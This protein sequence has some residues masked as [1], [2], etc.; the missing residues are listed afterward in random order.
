MFFGRR[1]N[2][3]CVPLIPVDE[4]PS[5]FRLKNV[6]PVLHQDE[7]DGMTCV[8]MLETS[9]CF[10]VAGLF[11][12]R[13]S[14]TPY[15][16]SPPGSNESLVIKVPASG[17]EM[18]IS[19][20][21]SPVSGS[22]QDV[23]KSQAVVQIPETCKDSPNS[24]A[25]KEVL[26]PGDDSPKLPEAAELSVPHDT[27][28]K[29]PAVIEA[30]GTDNESPQSPAVTQVPTPRHKSPKPSAVA[31][32]P[33]S[34]YNSPKPSLSQ[35]MHAPPPAETS[36]ENIAS[37]DRLPVK[38]PTLPSKFPTFRPGEKV[39]CT[40]WVRYGVCDFIQQGCKYRHEMPSCDVLKKITGM[41][42]MPLWWKNKRLQQFEKSVKRNKEIGT[43]KGKDTPVGRSVDKPARHARQQQASKLRTKKSTIGSEKVTV[44]DSEIIRRTTEHKG[45]SLRSQPSHPAMEATKDNK[46][47]LKDNQ[48]DL[49]DSEQLEQR[50]WLIDF[51]VVGPGSLQRSEAAQSDL[52]T[53]S[54]RTTIHAA[55]TDAAYFAP[56]T[57]TPIVSM[58]RVARPQSP[59]LN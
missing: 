53:Q 19:P 37:T 47:D 25:A 48:T 56:P 21:D 42:D 4:L 51:G 1:K 34:R 39:Y 57:T 13:S 22:C 28:P 20:V 45:R 46:T 44:S 17:D 55:G 29:S 43:D 8:G 5:V 12:K 14:S 54:R 2:G 15:P 40:H 49:M 10:E 59:T 9:G 11:D 16:M 33:G 52:P 27:S 26:S 50:A 38:P 23:S 35:S 32:A 36:A 41:R 6:K 18:P 58:E 3:D 31:S 30:Q 7:T 24:P